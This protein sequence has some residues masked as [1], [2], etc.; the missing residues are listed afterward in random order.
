MRNFDFAFRVEMGGKI[1][2][3]HFFRCL[4]LAEELRKR[5]KS[6]IFLVGDKKQFQS[7]D[8]KKF[9]YV[10]LKG[11]TENG[12]IQECKELM[13]KIKYLIIDLSNNEE[14]YEKKLKNY[15]TIMINDL[16]K[17]EIFSKILVNGSIVKKFQKYKIKNKFTRFFTGSKYMII[18]KEF[19]T[20]KK[21]VNIPEKMVK[22]ILLI[23]GGNDEK[24]ITV[25]VLPFFLKKN[26]QITIVLGP[27]NSH[28]QE[29]EKI[30]KKQSNVKVVTYP[31]KIA[32]LFSK[33]DLVI[34]STGITIYE[35]ACL[36]IPTIM[37]PINSVQ[38]E[39][40][41]EME[42]RGFGKIIDEKRFNLKRLERMYT[43]FENVFY[44][45]KMFKIGRK[46][47]DGNGTV[48][49]ADVLERII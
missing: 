24:K 27:T 7:H 36:G 8:S 46:I 47:I 26:I 11:K 32:K 16:G 38:K 2:S 28:K 25:K 49:I 15:N 33:Q 23:F 43:E 18:R 22:N 35:L 19:L 3:G 44:R 17:I 13:N 12:K 5:K 39:T 40:A 45:K 37:F 34:S 48:R 1:G 9:P 21:Y 4:A 14:K 20:E 42:I 41:K 30:V 31:K 10:E 6:V 29:I